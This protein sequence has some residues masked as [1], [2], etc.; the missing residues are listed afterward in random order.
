M[1][2]KLKWVAATTLAL[3]LTATSAQ[4]EVPAPPRAAAGWRIAETFEGSG[5]LD[6]QAI[7]ASGASN[8]WVLGLVPNPVPTFVTQRWN[9]RRWENVAL[10]AELH[11]VFGPWCLYSGV[12]TT[13][14]ADTW[15]FPV[16]PDNGQ[17][18]QYALRWTGSA[19]RTSEVTASADTVLDA[20]VFSPSDVWTFGEAGDS[21]L[22]IGPAVVRRW[23]GR[24]W[25]TAT[26]PLGTPVD[27]AAVG[28]DDIWA[29]GVSKATVPDQIQDI[30]PMH[31]N[32]ARWT[33]PRLPVFRPVKAGYPWVATAISATAH[34][35]WVAETPAVNE[36]T[37]YSPAGVILLRW[38]GSSWHTV[39]RN[40]H[41]QDVTSLTPD[42]HG[43][44]WLS[45][46]FGSDITDYRDGTFT[47]Q[48]APG[49]GGYVTQIVGV[50]GTD[51]SWAIGH[52]SAG[53]DILSYDVRF[54]SGGFGFGFGFG[55]GASASASA[56]LGRR[57]ARDYGTVTQ[58]IPGDGWPPHYPYNCAA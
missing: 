57:P 12:Y 25:R 36:S 51:S 41:V 56:D 42:G 54:A 47:S 29:L 15:F 14:P 45:S 32:G 21:F 1:F 43:G 26:V 18:V 50:P 30:I 13:S 48:P 52:L 40:A 44:F 37:G 58:D 16:L 24:D 23:N 38:N 33:S 6:L 55:F 28:P 22:P 8:A 46:T 27:V 53:N 4:A 34:G 7:A 20:A 11:N 2:R 3:A 31:W 49:Q 35:V 10:P 19:W 39:A 5:Y 9:G 17:P